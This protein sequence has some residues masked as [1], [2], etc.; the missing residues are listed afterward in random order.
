MQ[1]LR[2]N[3]WQRKHQLHCQTKSPGDFL[4]YPYFSDSPFAGIVARRY[5]RIL[6]EVEYVG[7]RVASLCQI[8]CKDSTLGNVLSLQ[9]AGSLLLGASFFLDGDV[10]LFLDYIDQFIESIGTE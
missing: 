5:S 8:V 2:W 7:N 1:Y 6:Q 10:E 4:L 3:V 9:H